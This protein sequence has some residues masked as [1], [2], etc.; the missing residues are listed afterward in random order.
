MRISRT[1]IAFGAFV[2]LLGLYL[3]TR[4]TTS[5]ITAIPS[6]PF[7]YLGLTGMLMVAAY[8]G[9]KTKMTV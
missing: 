9:R 8:I 1:R 6:L 4:L 5:G 2:N 7:V 3:T